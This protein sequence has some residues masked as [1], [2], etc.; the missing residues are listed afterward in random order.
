M[1][2]ETHTKE[3]KGARRR[4]WLPV[5]LIVALLG[6]VAAWVFANYTL[7]DGRLFRKGS[8]VDLSGAALD[9]ERYEELSEQHPDSR[10]V[11]DIPIGD[12]RYDS[13][14]ESIV[15]GDFS[16]DELDKFKLFENLKTVDGSRSHSYEAL[17]ALRQALPGCAVTWVV[18]LS[19]AESYPDD[20]TEAAVTGVSS[21][22]ALRERLPYLPFLQT[23]DLRDASFTGETEA[24][25]LAAE[26]P[27]ITFYRKVT[28]C[29]QT[30][31]NTV[32]S[33]SFPNLDK[34]RL[35]ELTA[36]G[37]SFLAVGQIDLGDTLYDAD[38][39][40]ALR[41][42]YHG[43]RVLC[44][45]RFYGVET[46]STAAELD[47]SGIPIEDTSEVDKAVGCMADLEKIIMSD[48]GIPDEEMDALNKK[49]DDVRVVWTVYIKGFACRTDA[50]DFCISRIT[51]HYG[52]I[53]ND[54]VA[55]LQYC[56]D[57]VTLDLG[58]MTFDDLFF[59]ANMPHLRFL[60]IGDTLV[61][62][63]S[64]LQNCY[65]L[66]YLEMFITPATDL[67]PLLDKTSLKHLN[68][69]YV[70]PDDYT[71]VFQ[72]TWLERLWWVSSYLSNDQMQA[73]RDAL[74]DTEV[75][76]FTADGSSV[77]RGWRYHDSYFEMRD[78]LGM[79]YHV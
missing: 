71:Q 33:L 54:H 38:A 35:D 16:V 12:G 72:M 15:I 74:P 53:T 22:A 56:T 31:D 40:L 52:Q 60:I 75:C 65:E 4:A 77:D 51:S 37:K 41:E 79:A 46:D 45:L 8:D 36:A 62:D 43:A 59:V 13:R 32:T 58:H 78:N 57:M 50:V 76:F 44:R 63:L 1:S 27:E 29:G 73:V 47:L 5:L 9:V 10:I 67:T 34:D 70:H 7:I 20:A 61:K 17:S 30:L 23:V 68:I 55:P 11:W 14:S 42:A 6:G 26:F 21:Y 24:E 66:Y 28:V 49:F 19:D 25:A 3:Q 64:P 69:S 18:P 39:I 2:K 48:C